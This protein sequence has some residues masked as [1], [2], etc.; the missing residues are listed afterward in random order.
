MVAGVRSERQ[1]SKPPDYFRI[2]QSSPEGTIQLPPPTIRVCIAPAGAD[3]FLVAVPGGLPAGSGL[4]P[5]ATVV[6]CLRH[7]ARENENTGLF[8]KSCG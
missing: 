4:R 7:Y 1:A 6:S 5:P 3:K 8:A 2:F